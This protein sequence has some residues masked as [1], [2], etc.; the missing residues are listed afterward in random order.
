MEIVWSTKHVLLTRYRRPK[1]VKKHLMKDNIS[2]RLGEEASLSSRLLVVILENKVHW[3]HHLSTN[4]LPSLP[5]YR[6]CCCCPSHILFA[7]QDTFPL[8]AVITD[9]KWLTEAHFSGELPLPAGNQFIQ[10][11]FSV[12]AP[13]PPLMV[14]NSLYTTDMPDAL[15]S[16][17]NNSVVFLRLQSSLWEQAEVRLQ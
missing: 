1:E 10:R 8:A 9:A 14:D 12:Y 6:S 11:Y 13:P 5:T 2:S 7:W 3:W 4:L 16:R 17:W 15:V